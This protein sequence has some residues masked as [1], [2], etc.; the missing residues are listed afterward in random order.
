MRGLFGL[1]GVREMGGTCETGET[2]DEI[3][4]I[5]RTDQIGYLLEKSGALAM[6]GLGIAFTYAATTSA[7]IS[8]SATVS[9]TMSRP[10]VT[11]T[12]PR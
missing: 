7:S 5:D 4:S 6:L 10:F 8:V 12:I 11:A 1:S 9:V 3:V 2:A